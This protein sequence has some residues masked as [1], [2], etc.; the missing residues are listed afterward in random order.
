MAESNARL[1]VLSEPSRGRSYDVHQG[2][3]SIGRSDRATIVIPDGTISGVHCEV[4][5][6]GDSYVVHDLGSTNGTRV[7][8]ERVD[9]QM[10][11]HSGDVLQVGEIE[12]LFD[13]DGVSLTTVS[14]SGTRV[15]DLEHQAH[16]KTSDM[17]NLDPL[18]HYKTP[19]NTEAG[20]Q[21]KMIIIFGVCLL[22]LVVLLLLWHW[23][24][25]MVGP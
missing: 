21:A 2:M 9:G 17:D 16:L 3:H 5:R 22:A 1:I 13:C 20:K 24:K 11:I 15:I 4:H 12:I 7:N 6:E 8:G 18:R 19:V 23:L 14:D 10:N 25:S